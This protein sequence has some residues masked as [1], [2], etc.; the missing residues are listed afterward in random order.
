MAA[1]ISSERVNIRISDL[2]NELSQ[3]SPSQSIKDYPKRG[4]GQ[5]QVTHFGRP[6]VKRFAL[7]YR[8]VVLSLSVCLS[9]LS[10]RDVGLLWP[11]GW[12]DQDATWHGGRPQP[13]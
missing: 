6:F 4:R 3:I 8:T 13:R 7:S 5:G 11:N 2:V 1:V 12:M 9:E 10:G